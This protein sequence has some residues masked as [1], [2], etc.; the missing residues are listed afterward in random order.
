M[1]PLFFYPGNLILKCITEVDVG[2][3]LY[4]VELDKFR[5][6]IRKS[7]YLLYIVSEELYAEKNIY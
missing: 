4:L 6:I 3:L 7:C 2:F 5:L 1:R